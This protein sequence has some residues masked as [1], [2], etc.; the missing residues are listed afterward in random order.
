MTLQGI[1]KNYSGLIATRVF[2]GTAE[3]GFFPAASYLLSIWYSR[4][5][6]QTKMSIFYSS[7]CI[8]SAFSGLLAFAIEKMSGV[9]GLGGWR[10]IFILEG[11]ATIVVGTSLALCLPDSPETARFLTE[12]E[13]NILTQRLNREY[14]RSGDGDERHSFQWKYLRSCITDVKLYLAVVIYWGNR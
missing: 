3:S 2:L 10:W 13:R 8:A 11:I 14:G 4:F 5:E 12:N 7:A 1:V 6:V 9:G